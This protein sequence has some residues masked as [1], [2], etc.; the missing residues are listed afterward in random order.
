MTERTNAARHAVAADRFVVVLNETQDLVNIAG[1]V[2]AM[3]NMGLR[4]LRLVNPAEYDERRITG[5]AHN[6]G[7]VLERVEHHESLRSALQD[8]TY[9]VGTTAR[10]RSARFVWQH[11]REA[12]PELWTMAAS[13]G[14]VALVFGREDAGMT[15]ED[16]DR[17]D[18]LLN[19]PTDPAHRSLNL[20]QA[21]L[22]VCYEI[23]LA[24]PGSDRPLPRSKKKAPP[25]TWEQ[26]RLLFLETE[27]A[28]HA[29]DFYKTRRPEAL[30]RTV[31]AVARRAGLD[32]QEA[33]FFRAIAIEIQKACGVR[34]QF[35]A[36]GQD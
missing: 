2:R 14:D 7:P 33:N 28:L 30:M 35:L 3:T 26:R 20:A 5:I 15:T 17:C 29:L 32:G 1:A 16:L 34:E 13:G 22:L 12:A 36:E 18:L 21:V 11:P 6:A 8:S 31:R 27:R 19:I 10:R 23:W 25:A 9:V 24:G 4:R